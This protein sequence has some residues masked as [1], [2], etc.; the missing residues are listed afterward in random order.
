V[1]D[2]EVLTWDAFGEASREVP[3]MLPPVTAAGESPT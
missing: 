1:T 2:R 3:V